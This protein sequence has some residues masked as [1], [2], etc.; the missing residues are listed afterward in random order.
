MNENAGPENAARGTFM[1]KFP[2]PVVVTA[3]FIAGGMLTRLWHPLWMLFLLIPMWY[4]YA[5]SL[6]ARTRRGR[7]A[8]RPVVPLAVL[9]F[10]LLGFYLRLW[11]I[12]WLLFVGVLIYYWYVIA[13]AKEN[14]GQTE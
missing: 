7:L 5:L 14:G 2:F 3:L 6:R 12:A 1:L 8:L 13:Y 10:L 4:L 11:R 9:L